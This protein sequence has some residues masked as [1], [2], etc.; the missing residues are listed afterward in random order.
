MPNMIN[1]HLSLLPTSAGRASATLR[2]RLRLPGFDALC[3][4]VEIGIGV[5]VVSQSAALRCRKS[6]AIRVVPLLDPWA[7]R[8][9]RLCVKSERALPAPARA[10]LDYLRQAH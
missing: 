5:A 1:D 3:R 8:R 7:H 9:L 10:L 2:P 6:M 4:V